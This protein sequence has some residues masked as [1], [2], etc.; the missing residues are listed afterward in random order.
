MNTNLMIALL[1]YVAILIGIPALIGV[2]VYRD[3]AGRGINRILWA[4]VAALTPAFIGL[5]I[6]LLMRGSYPDFK[7]PNCAADVKEQYTVCPNCGAKLKAG[8]PNCGFPAEP[9]W[10]VCP[11]CA[12]P[13]P[14]SWEGAT[15]PVKKKDTTL[16]K[17]LAVV[18]A[19]PVLLLLLL[20]L[21]SIRGFG[22][23]ALNTVQQTVGD[24]AGKPE[25]IAWLDTVGSKYDT[26]YALRYRTESR[27]QK[28]THYLIYCPAV[29]QNTRISS[30]NQAGLFG[31]AIEVRFETAGSSGAEAALTTVSYYAD[32]YGKLTVFLDDKKIPCEITDVDYKPILLE[33]RTEEGIP[34]NEE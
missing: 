32:E 3:A 23:S 31:N 10:M 16:W 33:G 34:A 11:R 15:P 1:V 20:V 28:V 6:Y 26:A 7:C 19:L 13:L 18:V 30:S 8:C 24:Y 14:E 25:V 21:F 4:L 17:I 5:I 29:D 12:S 9:N 27:D 22:N 2:Y